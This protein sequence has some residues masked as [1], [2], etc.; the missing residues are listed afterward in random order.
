MWV[1]KRYWLQLLKLTPCW[2]T[3]GIPMTNIKSR[4]NVYVCQYHLC[5]QGVIHFLLT[6]QVH[7]DMGLTIT[8]RQVCCYLVRSCLAIHLLVICVAFC[9]CDKCLSSKLGSGCLTLSASCKQSSSNAIYFQI[10][11][12]SCNIAEIACLHVLKVKI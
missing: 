8:Q 2:V 11:T 12:L 10:L 6:H 9:H 7:P 5:C 1:Q 4:S 3:L